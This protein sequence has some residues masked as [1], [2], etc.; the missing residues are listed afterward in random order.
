MRTALY[1]YIYDQCWMIGFIEHPIS[2][3]VKGEPFHIKYVSEMPRDRWFADPFILDYDD[4]FIQVLVE[5]YSYRIKRGRIAHLTIE[6]RSYRL[7]SYKIILDL[8]THLSFPFIERKEGKVYICP[9]NSESGSWCKY[10]YS[11]DSDQLKKVQVIAQE[12]LTD[13]IKTDVF[14]DDL[15]FATHIPSQNGKVMTVYDSKGEKNHEI[16]FQTNIARNAGDWFTIGDKVYR[17]AQDCNGGYGTAVILQE[18]KIDINGNYVLNDIRR[19]TS[20]HPKFATGCHTFNNYRD[21]TVVDVHGYRRPALVA[22]VNKLKQ[23]FSNI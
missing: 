21:I 23:M 19:I 15:I 18:V 1:K 11:V 2:G 13:A 14:G 9:E 10:E 16:E 7:V 4:K 5:E 20:T 17:P 3:I 6:R 22:T 8:P 12:P